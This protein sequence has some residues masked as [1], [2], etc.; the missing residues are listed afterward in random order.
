MDLKVTGMCFIEQGSGLVM[1][2]AGNKLP[3]KSALF[4]KVMPFIMII[5]INY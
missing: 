5:I 4:C 3:A 2:E 1:D